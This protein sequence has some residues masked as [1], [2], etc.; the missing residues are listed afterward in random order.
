[1]YSPYLSDAPN[2]FVPHSAGGMI[3]Y[4]QHV[5]LNPTWIMTAWFPHHFHCTLTVLL[6]GRHGRVNYK[7]L[8]DQCSHF[9]DFQ[10]QWWCWELEVFQL[11]SSLGSWE[12]VCLVMVLCITAPFVSSMITSPL[13]VNSILPKHSQHR[14]HTDLSPRYSAPFGYF[15]SLSTSAHLF[16]NTL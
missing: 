2:T 1:M 8:A 10:G 4:N 15:S 9:V 7:H 3:G 11:C 5:S 6:R 12:D 14:S 16:R 13:S